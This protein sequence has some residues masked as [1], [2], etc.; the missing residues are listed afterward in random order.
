MITTETFKFLECLRKRARGDVTV[1]SPG[2]GSIKI[3]G[4]EINYFDD[5]QCREQVSGIFDIPRVLYV[6]HDI[7]RTSKSALF[8]LQIIFFHV[9]HI[10]MKNIEH[11]SIVTCSNKSLSKLSLQHKNLYNC[12]VC[13]CKQKPNDTC[14]V[15][16]VNDRK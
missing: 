10:V 16:E 13:S 2:T 6:T 11:H 3:N 12:Q 5:K 15:V 4:Q 1:I 14:I 8:S 7:K 9:F